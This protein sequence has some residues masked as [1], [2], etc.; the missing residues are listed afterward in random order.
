MLF[1]EPAKS[2]CLD[3]GRF[4]RGFNRC[5]FSGGE[6]NCFISRADYDKLMKEIYERNAKLRG[7]ECAK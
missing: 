3:C 5:Y 4:W 7:V 1:V 6:G 2:P